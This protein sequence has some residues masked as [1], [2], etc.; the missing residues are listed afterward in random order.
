MHITS[1]KF[2]SGVDIFKLLMSFVESCH[3]KGVVF[4]NGYHRQVVLRD[5]YLQAFGLADPT[6]LHGNSLDLIAMTNREGHW[7]SGPLSRRLRDYRE[8]RIWDYYKLNWSEWVDQPR[9][10]V[11]QQLADAIREIEKEGLAMTKAI[12]EVDLMIR[13]G[14]L[15]KSLRDQYISMKIKK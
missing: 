10:M 15:D 14:K 12:N 2:G 13:E 3:E 9:Y 4:K 1:D 6:K 5:L 8:F 7:Q 11:E